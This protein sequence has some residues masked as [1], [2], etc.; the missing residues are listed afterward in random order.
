MEKEN[1]I[2]KDVPNYEGYYQVSDLGRVKSLS[3]TIWKGKSYSTYKGIMLKQLIGTTGYYFVNLSKNQKSKIIKVHQLVTIVFLGHK[4]CG[5]KIV[6]DHI[7][8]N[9]LDNR[10]KNLQ[11]ITHRENLSKDRINRSSKYI[12]VSFIKSVNKWRSKI[13][14]NKKVNHLGVFDTEEEA[15][16]Y[17]QNA[18]KAI[19]NNEEIVIKKKTKKLGQHS[20]PSFSFSFK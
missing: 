18:L 4:P 3:R 19:E 16:E 14:S 5:Y 15:S 8:N 9:R 10:L 20:Y 13:G 2:W 12:G 1:E 7:N 6:V 17:Y 11:L